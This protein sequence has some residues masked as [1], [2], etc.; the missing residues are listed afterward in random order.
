MDT[1]LS[2]I[3]SAEFCEAV[4]ED[5]KKQIAEAVQRAR[6]L[7]EV[8]DVFTSIRDKVPLAAKRTKK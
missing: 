4:I 7:N 6:D 8:V 3:F 5:A 2:E 1:P